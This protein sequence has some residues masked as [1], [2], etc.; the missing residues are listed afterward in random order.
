MTL[1]EVGV[2]TSDLRSVAHA[3]MVPG[4][5]ELFDLRKRW[6]LLDQGKRCGIGAELAWIWTATG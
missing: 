6:V 2:S 3:E 1:M 4:D 5:L